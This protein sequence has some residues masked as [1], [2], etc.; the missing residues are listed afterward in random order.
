MAENITQTNISRP[1]PYLEAAG[2][3]IMDLT[4]KL[5]G[6]PIDTSKF[7]P[8]IAGQNVL[9]QQ[10]QQQA[11]TQ[12][13]LG[14]L[15]FDPT[16]GAVT[17]AGA[18]T[19]IA[20]YQP[21]LDQAAAYSGPQ[22]YQQFMSP[23]QQDVIDTTLSQYD[24]QAQK[25]MQ[26]LAANQVNAGAFGQGRGQVQQAEYQSQSDMNRALLQAQ[27]Q[28]Q[29]YG[30]AQSA[31]AQ[32]QQQQAGLASLQPSLAQSGIQ[33][34]GAAGTSNLAYQQAIQ[35]AQSQAAQTAAYEPYNRMQFLSA[36]TGGL[37]SGQPQA[38]MSQASTN[39]PTA[40][41]LSS[42]LSGAATI[43]G[44]GSLYNR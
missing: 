15:T 11:A 10:A 4:T 23:Y 33:Q 19:G 21:F 29:G 25:G 39:Q 14:T 42:A 24:I 26:P 43:Y 35:D 13:G 30:Q 37:L 40:S 6:Q 18:G 3:T 1:A 27:L 34:L 7:A 28:Q 38:Y 2:Q 31:A 32:A 20:G 44:L 41:P 12:G 17:G 5:T 22:A 16:T 9:T 8:Q 36:T